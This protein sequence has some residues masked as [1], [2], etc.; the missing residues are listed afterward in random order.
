M[1]HDKVAGTVIE[2]VYLKVQSLH[3]F[4]ATEGE[5]EGVD[6]LWREAFN[7]LNFAPDHQHRYVVGFAVEVWRINE[8]FGIA[9]FQI[10]FGAQQD[11]GHTGRQFVEFSAIVT[12]LIIVAHA[13][14]EDERLPLVFQLQIGITA[15]LATLPC[16][17]YLGIYGENLFEIIAKLIAHVVKLEMVILCAETDAPFMIVAYGVSVVS[18]HLEAIVLLLTIDVTRDAAIVGK[19]RIQF[20]GQIESQGCIRHR[21]VVNNLITREIYLVVCGSILEAEMTYLVAVAQVGMVRTGGKAG[22]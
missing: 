6:T 4:I 19:H 3:P 8:R 22:L 20:G 21:I 16:F 11:E 7:K 10:P 1:S 2:T 14:I 12:L 17:T 18:F 9:E 15:V 5:L 13:S